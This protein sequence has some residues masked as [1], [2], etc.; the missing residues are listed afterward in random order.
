M[1]MIIIVLTLVSLL[2]SVNSDGDV[3][4]ERKKQQ[5]APEMTGLKVD[6]SGKEK[7]KQEQSEINKRSADEPK[8]SG[9]SKIL[10]V[11]TEPIKGTV[12]FFKNLLPSGSGS[13]TR[14]VGG[15]SAMNYKP[16]YS[17]FRMWGPG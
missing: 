9:L 7:F 17:K 10:N 13:D 11:I 2:S 5:N 4:S 8:Q 3:N 15:T 12:R 16:V 14:I 1:K 6:N